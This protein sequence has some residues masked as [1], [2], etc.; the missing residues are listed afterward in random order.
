MG[1][2]LQHKL[3]TAALTLALSFGALPRPRA[4]LAANSDSAS[5]KLMVSATILKHAHLKILSQVA[6]VR[7]TQ[8]DIQ[9]GYA[10]VPTGSRL[11]IHSNSPDGYVLMFESQSD[12]VRE[13]Q[14]KGLGNTVQLSAQGGVVSQTQ[15]GGRLTRITVDLGFRF[16]LSENAQPG[17]YAWPLRVSVMPL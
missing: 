4:A 13:T 9:R 11:E 8:A 10:D 12:F 14:V 16:L 1:T 5:T 6:A 3:L 15:L 7:I 17:T 2:S